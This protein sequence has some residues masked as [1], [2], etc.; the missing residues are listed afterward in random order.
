[1]AGGAGSEA[2]ADRAGKAAVDERHTTRGGMRAQFDLRIRLLKLLG[3]AGPRYTTALVAVSLLLSFLPAVTAQA[4]G[5]LVAALEKRPSADTYLVPLLAL[6]TAL[7]AGQLLTSL[8]RPLMETTRFRINAAQWERVALL[9]VS[10]PRI[11]ELE[12]PEVQNLLTRASTRSTAGVERALG[13]GPTAVVT[14]L[15]GILGALASALILARY[16]WW[17]VPVLL[18]PALAIRRAALR[19][20]AELCETTREG[21]TSK[22]RFA[23]FGDVAIDPSAAKELRVFGLRDWVTGQGR[24]HMDRFRTPLTR[25]ELAEARGRSRFAL[26]TLVPLGVVF[27]VIGAWTA[28]GHGAVSG[29]TMVL[30]SAW[31]VFSVVGS[32]VE[33]VGVLGASD[34]LDAY[35]ELTRILPPEPAPQHDAAATDSIPAQLVVFDNVSFAYDGGRRVLDGLDLE[36]RPGELLAIVGLNGAGKSTLT[37]LLA[38]LYRP[39]SGR[40][41]ANG[42]DITEIG[43]T[44]WRR[45]LTIVFQEFVRYHLPARDNVALGRGG[46]LDDAALERAARDSGFS[47][48]LALLPDGW[49]TP[50]SRARSGGVDLSG[51]QWQQVVLARALYAVHTG[52]R[53]LVLDEPTAHLDVETEFEVF[54]RLAEI[55]E[56]GGGQV[57]VVLISHR[58]STVRQADRIALLDGGKIT[59][60]GSHDE[61]MALG[62]DYMKLFEIQ[63]ERFR[64][65]YDDRVQEGELL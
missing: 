20:T 10:T 21:M 26:A 30:T 35:D 56:L 13:E 4:T 37:K 2:A 43:S 36:I 48:V 27:A 61:L 19:E 25:L 44:R 60:C 34:V 65:G 63:A 38:G 42:R 57:A 53:I 39:I 3:D 49:D 7:L 12:R 8:T 51:G 9:S 22:R 17:L 33:D 54:R 59:E 31:A 1:M 46:P 50:L 23:Y 5:H 29:E 18:L 14:Q 47:D 64:D 16:S 41:T 40:I 24:T 52:S 58:L 32:T 62:G 55:R 11:D 6:G 45:R 15:S 28:H